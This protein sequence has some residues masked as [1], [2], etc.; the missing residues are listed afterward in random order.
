MFFQFKLI[1]RNDFT[2]IFLDYN[3]FDAE[4]QSVH[5]RSIYMVEG[6]CK[7]NGYKPMSEIWSGALNLI[8]HK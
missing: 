8:S 7:V 1:L 3:P 5:K 6:N 4:E 2:V